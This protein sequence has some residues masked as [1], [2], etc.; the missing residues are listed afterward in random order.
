MKSISRTEM[1]AVEGG[2]W[3]CLECKKKFTL[4]IAMWSIA[5]MCAFGNGFR[6]KWVW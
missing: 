1:R 5:H 2:R 4:W 6:Y 3:Q